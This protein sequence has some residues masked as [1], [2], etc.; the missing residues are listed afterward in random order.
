MKSNNKII[1]KIE[2]IEKLLNEVKEEI[3]FITSE[4]KPVKEKTKKEVR[5]W[6][7]NSLQ[8]EF[9]KLYQE[10]T[11]KNDS[12]LINNFVNEKSVIYLKDFCKANNI[13]LDSK[14]GSKDK[15]SNEILKWFTQRKA[16]SKRL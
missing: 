14:N 7:H 5:N 8:S 12:S 3:N 13:S 15:I 2:K 16:I 6:D 9:D 1:R 11:D 4:Q 10:Y